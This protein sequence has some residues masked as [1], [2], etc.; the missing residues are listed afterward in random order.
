MV[1]N[2]FSTKTNFELY[3]KVI[4]EGA[5]IVGEIIV[6][7]LN[8][9]TYRSGQTVKTLIRLQSDQS[10]HCLPFQLHLLDALLQ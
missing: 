10:L 9:G 2:N 5:P 6:K 4:G 3:D 1:V 7:I 8:I